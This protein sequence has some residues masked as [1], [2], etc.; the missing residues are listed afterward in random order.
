MM[1]IT[2]RNFGF[3]RFYIILILL[4]CTNGSIAQTRKLVWADEFNETAID[5][6]K[7]KFGSGLTNDNI[8]FYTDRTENARIVDGKLHVIARKESYQGF[9]YTSSLLETSSPFNWRYGRMEARIKLP[10]TP[11]FVPA[12]WML[13]ADNV[14]AGGRSAA[15]WISWNIRQLK[16]TRYTARFT[17]KLIT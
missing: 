16:A 6:S 4:V 2:S 13:P 9:N 7:W 1:T 17:P 12:F 3:V 15:R 11:G 8:H 14:F 10:G 5:R